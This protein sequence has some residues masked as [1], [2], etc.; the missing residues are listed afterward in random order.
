MRYVEQ[1]LVQ[2]P[3]NVEA[4]WFKANIALYGPSDPARALSVLAQLQ[5][6]AE[7]TPEI[8]EQVAGLV[9]IAQ[10]QQSGDR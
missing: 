4:L 1:A 3:A 10:Q 8:R 6:R 5:Q 7:L 9:Q 2:D